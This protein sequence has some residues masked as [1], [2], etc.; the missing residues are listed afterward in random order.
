MTNPALLDVAYEL[1]ANP[2]RRAVLY[3]FSSSKIGSIDELSREIAD[4]EAAISSASE[5]DG[6]REAVGVSLVHNHLPRLESHGII[7]YDARSGDVVRA[8]GYEA[9][10]PF[11]ERASVLESEEGSTT[12][13][14]PATE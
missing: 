11:V 4:R 12:E 6:V 2:Q 9:I 7:E 1:L 3:Y 10:R 14:A 13:S 5:S 8:T